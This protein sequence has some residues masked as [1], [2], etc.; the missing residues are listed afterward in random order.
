MNE[1]ALRHHYGRYYDFHQL[2]SQ[3]DLSASTGNNSSSGN[4]SNYYSDFQRNNHNYYNQQQ[5]H[6]SNDCCANYPSESNN[7]D[8]YNNGSASP[9]LASNGSAAVIAAATTSAS[10]D[11]GGY[12]S[13][14]RYAENEFVSRYGVTRYADCEKENS[15]SPR[16]VT[17]TIT[18]F[19]AAPRGSSAEHGGSSTQHQKMLKSYFDWGAIDDILPSCLYANNHPSAPVD[20]AGYPEHPL[21]YHVQTG[22]PLAASSPSSSPQQQQHHHGGAFQKSAASEENDEN[23]SPS[24]TSSCD[25]NCGGDTGNGRKM[26]PD[27]CWSS[28]HVSVV[29]HNS[30]SKLGTLESRCQEEQKGK[31]VVANSSSN[32][33]NSVNDIC[34]VH[35]VATSVIQMPTK[36]RFC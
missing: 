21:F 35:G 4:S 20:S 24:L 12:Y 17:S 11:A 16:E 27:F 34:V 14:D 10:R 23:T 13:Q 36:K 6:V 28:R 29:R 25:D 15:C 32:N 31:M 5:H 26:D 33:N 8:D 2:Q 22:Y 18:P 19:S 30:K 9:A 7:D 3:Q 1:M